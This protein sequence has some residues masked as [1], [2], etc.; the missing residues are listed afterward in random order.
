M[1]NCDEYESYLKEQLPRKVLIQLN[2]EFQIMAEHAKQRLVE[3]VREES[4]ATLAGFLREKGFSSENPS[5][6]PELRALDDMVPFSF[7]VLNH[8]S[9]FD[10]DV[11]A[12]WPPDFEILP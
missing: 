11:D 4:V 6:E 2:K 1:I 3:I 10:V 9:I 7:E 8:S 12:A 5:L